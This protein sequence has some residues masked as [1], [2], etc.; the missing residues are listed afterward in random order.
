V[1]KQLKAWEPS[2]PW[3]KACFAYHESTLQFEHLGDNWNLDL[4]GISIFLFSFLF[5]KQRGS[6]VQ[7]GQLDE[8]WNPHCLFFPF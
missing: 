6:N 3:D 8:N 1:R 5:Y 4:T 2:R 7:F